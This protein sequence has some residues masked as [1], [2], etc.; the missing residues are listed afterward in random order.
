MAKKSEE[1]KVFITGRESVCDE[2]GEDLGRGAWIQLTGERGALCLSCADLDHLIFLPAGDAALT[3]RSKKH[4]VLW[5]VV[6]KWSRPRKRYERQGLLVEQKALERAETECLEDA[7]VRAR[8]RERAAVRR[9]ELDQRYLE[10]FA[11]QVRRLY[12]SCPRGREEV[13]AEHACL[14]YSGR[15]GR[16]AAAKRLD[17][18]MLRLAVRAHVRHRETKYDEYLVRGDGRDLARAAIAEDVD[19]VLA[20][21]QRPPASIRD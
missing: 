5:A 7:E 16:S 15:V 6:L 14:K 11:A 8:R 18:E 13:I 21:W 19:R 17:E 9:T 10:A 4:S 2:C 1:I 12:P 3:R 20:A